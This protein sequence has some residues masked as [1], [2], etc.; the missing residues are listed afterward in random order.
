[1]WKIKKM[2]QTNFFSWERVDDSQWSWQYRCSTVERGTRAIVA[3]VS[4]GYFWNGREM[5]ILNCSTVPVPNYGLSS[6]SI[7]LYSTYVH[8][9]LFFKRNSSLR[10]YKKIWLSSSL[11]KISPKKRIVCLVLFCSLMIIPVMTRWKKKS[12]FFSF[13]DKKH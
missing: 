12:A 2:K 11:E 6:F 8:I 1:M 9:R 5:F 4:C 10:P 7:I 13:L 3:K